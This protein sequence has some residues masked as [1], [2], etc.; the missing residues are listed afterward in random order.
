MEKKTKKIIVVV[1][2]IAVIAAVVGAAA[3]YNSPTQKVQRLLDLGQQYLMAEDYE[4]A[5]AIF[6]E[7]LEIDANNTEAYKGLLSAYSGMGD[8]DGINDTLRRAEAN[9]NQ[10]EELE[11]IRVMAEGALKKYVTESGESE[12]EN[13]DNDAGNDSNIVNSDESDALLARVYE[14]MERGEALTVA[15]QIDASEEA[16]AVAEIMTEDYI[17]YA[18]E[19]IYDGFSGKASGIY[20]TDDGGYYFFYGDIKDGI[21]EGEGTTCWKTGD[22]YEVFEGDWLYDA[23]NG[24]GT[25]YSYEQYLYPEITE[26]ITMIRNGYY[27]NGRENGDFVVEFTYVYQE[28]SGEKDVANATMHYTAIDGD[29]PEADWRNA[30]Y[31]IYDYGEE[32][33]AEG[34]SIIAYADIFYSLADGGAGQFTEYLYYS[35]STHY[36]GAPGFEN[37]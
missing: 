12:I 36:L 30:V 18:P 15:Q 3:W 11:E 10:G 33:A 4:Q 24:E 6:D 13:S 31:D 14:L 22:R 34:N 9:L 7:V 1:A 29:A 28:S 32:L 16:S 21:R 5:V 19:G 2:V 27:K 35:P 8:V 20:R 25:E 23:P 26:S 17:L 37:R